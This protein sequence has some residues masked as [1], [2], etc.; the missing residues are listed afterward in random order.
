MKKSI[1]F[2]FLMFFFTASLF[3]Q[4]KKNNSGLEPTFSGKWEASCAIQHRSVAM[5][6]FCDL[7]PFIIDPND[8]S[9]AQL[10]KVML[11]FNNGNVS[12]ERNGE[13]TTAPFTVDKETHALSFQLKETNYKFKTFYSGKQIILL[14]EDG[15]S[16]VLL[17]RAKG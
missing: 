3:A 8:Q 1:Q 16:P 6:S 5:M 13:T 12:I 14:D 15:G 17:K 7:C 11:T 10:K 9:K 4:N 2:C